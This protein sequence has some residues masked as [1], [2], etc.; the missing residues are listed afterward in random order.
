MGQLDSH[1]EN[2]EIWSLPY[3]IYKNLILLDSK[4]KCKRQKKNRAFSV[5]IVE[6]FYLEAVSFL[7]KIL[8]INEKLDRLTKL[9][10]TSCDHNSPLRE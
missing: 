2:E 7:N 9:N 3:I 1:M 4:P 5:Y 10:R 8:I 6:Y